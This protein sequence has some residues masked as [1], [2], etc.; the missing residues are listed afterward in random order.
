MFEKQIIYLES[1]DSTNKYLMDGEFG[2][3]SVVS[4]KCQT[5]GKGR[6]GREW[7]Y[8]PGENLFFSVVLPILPREKLMGA[9]IAAGY[10]IVETLMEYADIRLKWPNDIVCADRKLGGL[11]IETHFAG[12]VLKKIVFG[13][14][15]NL[16]SYPPELSARAT[17]LSEFTDAEL[18]PNVI[19]KKALGQLGDVFKTYTSG[20]LDIASEWAYYSAYYSKKMHFHRNGTLKILIEKGITSDGRLIAQNEQGEEEIITEGEIG[21]DFRF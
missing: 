6:G 20:E 16:N 10:A 12:S 14:G 13:A 21:Y 3:G 2:Q 5:H 11:L 7:K 9:Q 8:A 18:L 17:S 15:I 1:V 4:A 19:L